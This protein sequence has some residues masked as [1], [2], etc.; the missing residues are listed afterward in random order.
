MAIAIHSGHGQ[1]QREEWKLTLEHLVRDAEHATVF[2][3]WNRAEMIEEMEALKETD[4]EFIVE[5]ERN[6]WAGMR[7][8]L[9][10]G[11]EGEDGVYESCGFWYVVGGKGGR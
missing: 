1:E 9:E 2:T 10:V 7:K 11:E 8:F 3:T 5:G 4:A 6:K